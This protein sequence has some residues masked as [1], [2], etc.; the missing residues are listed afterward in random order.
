MIRPIEPTNFLRQSTLNPVIDVRAPGEFAQGHIPGA[1]NIPL[2]DDAERAEVGT[3]Y[4][5]AGREDAVLRGLDF[6]VPKTDWYLKSL[7]RIRPGGRILVHCWRGGMRSAA[8]AE[9]FSN[10]GYEVDLLTGGYKAYRRHIREDLGRPARIVVLGGLTGSGK[11]GLLHAIASAGEQVVDLEGLAC[12]KGSVFGA[13]GQPAQPTNEQFENNLHARWS[14]LD[15]SR[16]VWLEDESRMIGKVTLPDPV[17]A[18][19]SNGCLLIVE[20]DHATR[21]KRL[22]NEYAG[23]DKSLLAEAIN[24]IADRLGGANAREAVM[25][26]ES[27]RF[28]K[29]AAIVLAYYDKAYLFS[30]TRRKSKNVHN[31]PIQGAELESDARKIIEFACK[32]A[33]DGNDLS[34]L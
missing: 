16:M 4:V 30:I 33:S 20:P 27:N 24:R 34:R 3:L 29:V 1:F 31:I 22:V 18:H 13:L 9:L 28:E 26:L 11:T 23:F 2:F 5:Q 32:Y 12:H 6:A 8:M 15:L 7:R 14:Q 17:V 10:A 25:A 21:I 19:I